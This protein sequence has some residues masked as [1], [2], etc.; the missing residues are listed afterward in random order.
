MPS[1]I[2][3]IIFSER[4]VSYRHRQLYALD[5]D[6]PVIGQDNISHALVGL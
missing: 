1:I 6:I 2:F 4:K 3:C 5:T